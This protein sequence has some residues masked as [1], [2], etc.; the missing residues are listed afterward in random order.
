MEVLAG[1]QYGG[2]YPNRDL[3]CMDAVES[4]FLKLA[5]A[6]AEAGWSHGEVHC[7]LAELARD[8]I[9]VAFEKRP[10]EPMASQAL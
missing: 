9:R 6:M 7:A 3:D 8:H 5:D 4:S 10:R 1:P 2:A